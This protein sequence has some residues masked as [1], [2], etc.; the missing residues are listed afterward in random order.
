MQYR[1][2]KCRLRRLAGFA[3]TGDLPLMRRGG[4]SRL[5]IKAVFQSVVNRSIDCHKYK[6]TYN[7][8]GLVFIPN[9]RW[10]NDSTHKKGE[11]ILLDQLINYCA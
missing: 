5:L 11:V 1:Q 9:N 2:R 4:S 7:Q 10:N 3:I 6:C 8:Y